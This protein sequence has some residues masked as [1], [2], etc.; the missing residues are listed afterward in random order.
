MFYE[1]FQRNISCGCEKKNR[2]RIEFGLSSKKETYASYLRHAK[3]RNLIFDLE[4]DYFLSL[5]QNI[6]FYCG[7]PPAT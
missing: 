5:T 3:K 1:D 7:S 6:C 2:F 4:F